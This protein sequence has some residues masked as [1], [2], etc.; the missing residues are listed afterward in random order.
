MNLEVKILNIDYNKI[1]GKLINLGAKEQFGG[2]IV[3]TY[4]DTCENRYLAI[5]KTFLVQE[6]KSEDD[7]LYLCAEHR[8]PTINA[9]VQETLGTSAETNEA[10]SFLS[11]FNLQPMER[12]TKYAVRHHLGL[13]LVELCKPI[14]PDIPPWMSITSET[15]QGIILAVEKLDYTM[16]QTIA[17]SE[18]HIEEHYS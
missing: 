18:R 11:H 4:C 12:T 3:T 14:G 8:H 1:L 9:L 15:E 16:G 6:E 17:A 2:E 7:L 13:A 10:L 5:D